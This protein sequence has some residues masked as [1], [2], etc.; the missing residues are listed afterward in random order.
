MGDV[1]RV[2]RE[3]VPRK[4]DFSACRDVCDV[5]GGTGTLLAAILKESP[6]ARGTLFDQPA[7][8]AKA[9]PV[10]EAAG[11]AERVEVVGGDFFAAVPEGRDRY[12]LQAIV[13]DWDDESCVKIL[14]NVRAAMAPDA[15]VLVLEQE[16]PSHDGWHIVK[17]VDLEML[18]DTGAGRERTRAEFTALFERADLRIARTRALPVLT[19]F[20][21]AAA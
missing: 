13:H 3:I 17:A 2:Q 19:I 8:V 16:M 15:R 7:V 18:V 11:V 4:H 14:G 20:E 5:G 9:A 1:S 12:L 10:L 21:L 6:R